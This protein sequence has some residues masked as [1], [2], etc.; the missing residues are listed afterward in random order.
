M[1]EGAA[2]QLHPDRIAVAG[3]SVGGNMTAALAL[4]AKERGDVAVRPTVDALPG[5]RRGHGNG[6]V[7][8]FAEGYFLTAKTMARFWDAYVPEV[9]QRLEPYR[10]LSVPT[11][12]SSSAFGRR[13]S[14]ST[15]LTSCVTRG[16]PMRPSAAG[17]E[18]RDDRPL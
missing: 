14:S 11:T 17:R 3:D 8:Q 16:R 5:D 4:M 15:R 6:L 12:R 9:D 1:R 10:H 18:C 2:N 13:S 7:E